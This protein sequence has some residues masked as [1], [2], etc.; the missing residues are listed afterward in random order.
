[1]GIT[2]VALDL[3]SDVGST[4]GRKRKSRET[5]QQVDGTM[6]LTIPLSIFYDPVAQRKLRTACGVSTTELPSVI[7]AALAATAQAA[8]VPDGVGLRSVTA[9]ALAE[10]M[11][12]REGEFSRDDAMQTLHETK[13]LQAQSTW[14]SQMSTMML[15]LQRLA[16]YSVGVVSDHVL[17]QSDSDHQ[18][19]MASAAAEP[20]PAGGGPG[21]PQGSEHAS[22]VKGLIGS[23]RGRA[24]ASAERG[25]ARDE[26]RGEEI[27]ERDETSLAPAAR[28]KSEAHALYKQKVVALCGGEHF[29]FS[30][31]SSASGLHADQNGGASAAGGAGSGQN[32]EMDEKE[33]LKQDIVAGV[34]RRIS[35]FYDI[36]ASQAVLPGEQAKFHSNLHTLVT[37]I[38]E[39]A[40]YHPRGGSG[41]GE[42]DRDLDLVR[43][44][45]TEMH[46]TVLDEQQKNCM[47]MDATL[48][49]SKLN[50]FV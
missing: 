30:P 13:K 33:A 24:L 40:L 41:P 25:E 43:Q 16:L 46:K 23:L 11:F 50:K 42:A 27:A 5:A 29:T 17:R 49:R 4:G 22:D 7:I 28:E 44:L 47:E 15:D 35:K 34:L 2:D 31:A 18:I 39:G 10:A 12:L 36:C 1:M 45:R 26:R 20:R 19:Q 48:L 37:D 9:M 38:V 8:A 32:E 6:G 3:A 21:A 14:Q